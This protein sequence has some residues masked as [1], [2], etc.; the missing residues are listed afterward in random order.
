[1][2]VALVIFEPFVSQNPEKPAAPIWRS[3]LGTGLATAFAV[4]GI[5]ISTWGWRAWTWSQSGY[6]PDRS[7]LAPLVA[8]GPFAWLVASLIVGA[9]AMLVHAIAI[10]KGGKR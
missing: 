4:M 7:L 2:E 8:A 10:R 1:M 5:L 9:I 6:R 3:L